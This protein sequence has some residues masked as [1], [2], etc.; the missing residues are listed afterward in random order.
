MATDNARV[1]RGRRHAAKP[2]GIG[3]RA[4]ALLVCLARPL[5]VCALL[6]IMAGCA[7]RPGPEA[8]NSIATVPP[9]A[10]LVT[11]YVETTRSRAAADS[12]VFTTDRA[13][14]PNY[15]AFTIAI[16]PG[17]KPGQIEWTKGTADPARSFV[18][19]KQE[20]LDSAGFQRQ[21][22]A[23]RAARRSARVGVFVHG[24]NTSFQEALFRLAQMV[25]DS[26]IDGV[27]VL[28]AWPSEAAVTGYIADK[29][30]ATYSRDSLVQLLTSLTQGSRADRVTVIGH[31]MG[32]WLTVEALRQLRLTGR[33][34][35]LDRLD[36]ILAAPDIDM[37]LFRAQMAVIGP[38]PTP[39]T[40]LVS[41][42]DRALSVASRLSGERPRLG[43]LDINDARIQEAAL[44]N[45]LQIIDI[46][47]LAASDSFNH[48]RY[49]N[50]AQLY[51]SLAATS[52]QGA[53][54]D[55][56]RAGAFIFNAVGTTLSSPFDLAGRALAPE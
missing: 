32:G 42:D 45:N 11:V 34:A 37:D 47:K 5:Q 46:S 44:K 52:G 51:P 18:I 25:A 29:D 33:N 30:A 14:S 50:L 56:R 24:Y 21:I 36:V 31:S 35:V 15:A 38:L 12:N 1:A 17:H 3:R 23:K 2:G 8:L 13:Q 20:I 16:P 55:L 54:Q 48:D 53:G 28:F 6:L 49:A 39:I 27:P 43:S 19:V 41:S 22:A 7:T 9:G 40:V 26:D 4:M 10:K